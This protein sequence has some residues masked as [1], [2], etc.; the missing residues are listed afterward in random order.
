MKCWLFKKARWG[1]CEAPRKLFIR[2]QLLQQSSEVVERQQQGESGKS[3]WTVLDRT[4]TWLLNSNFC[5]CLLVCLVFSL[6]LSM[7]S[8]TTAFVLVVPWQE[9]YQAGKA[10]RNSGL[11]KQR[12]LWPCPPSL[13]LLLPREGFLLIT[14]DTFQSVRLFCKPWLL[15]ACIS[16]LSR[17]QALVQGYCLTEGEILP[18]PYPAVT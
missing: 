18:S 16:K 17:V 3:R 9:Y 5:Y 1:H 14:S 8:L 4:R 15:E 7:N 12:W 11:L 6:W 2:E 10:L 13:L